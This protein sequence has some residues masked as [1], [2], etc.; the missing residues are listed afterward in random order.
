MITRALI[1]GSGIAGG[2][3]VTSPETIA[4]AHAA[5]EHCFFVLIAV[6]FMLLLVVGFQAFNPF[7]ARR[8][9]KPTWFSNPFNLRDP[10]QF[11]H[12]G[13]Y[14][15][16]AGGLGAL[17][18][19]PFRGIIALPMALLLLACGAGVLLGIQLCIATLRWKF[20]ND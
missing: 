8:W 7:S 18:S 13:A 5:S 9:T 17:L 1:A 2:P 3:F 6:P 20:K 15:F 14:H 19:V 10:L 12:M 16:L 4:E 11:F